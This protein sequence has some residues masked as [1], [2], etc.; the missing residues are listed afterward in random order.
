MKLRF[1]IDQAECFRRG[2]DAPKSIVTIEIDPAK[3]PVLDRHAIADRLDGIDVCQLMEDDA[4]KGKFVRAHHWPPA[5]DPYGDCPP[6]R[7]VANTP[8]YD[9]LMEA[10]RQEDKRLGRGNNTSKGYTGGGDTRLKPPRQFNPRSTAA[11]SQ[12]PQEIDDA[13]KRGEDD[14]KKR[15]G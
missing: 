3:I 8:D 6:M 10:I 4:E 9:G 13:K 2:I 14:L 7:L 11:Q 12:T 5:S 15:F 1:E